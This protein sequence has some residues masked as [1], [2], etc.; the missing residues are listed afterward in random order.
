MIPLV[1]PVNTSPR[2]DKAQQTRRRIVRAAHAEF[3]ENGY[4]GA[5]IADI[6]RRAGVATQTVYFVFHTKAD[7]ISAAIDAAVMGE[8]VPLTPQQS[9]WWAAMQACPSAVEALRTFIR[10][11]GPVFARTAQLAEVMRS[12]ALADAEVAATRERHDTLQRTGFGQA[13]ANISAKGPLRA[14]LDQAT[15]T[16]ILLTLY[17]DSTYIQMTIDHGWSHAQ[18][19]DWMCDAAP[20]LLLLDPGEPD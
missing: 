1:T 11:A 14:G 16:D 8:P 9:E 2:R 20:R 4:H 13:V 19:I 12:A 5:T 10:G 3:I 6:A 7:L 17:G 18:F 15:A